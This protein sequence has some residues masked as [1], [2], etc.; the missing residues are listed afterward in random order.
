MG[1]PMSTPMPSIKDLDN[2]AFWQWVHVTYGE[3]T[4]DERDYLPEDLERAPLMSVA[5][6]AHRYRL[7]LAR[8]I[9][10]L[11]GEWKRQIAKRRSKA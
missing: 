7:A 3:I 1:I 2:P 6:H 11:C 8:K 5:E 4:P 10:R 9:I